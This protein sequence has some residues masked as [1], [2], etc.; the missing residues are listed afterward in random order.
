MMASTVAD[1]VSTSRAPLAA[2]PGRNP[3]R[4]RAR[5]P[6]IASAYSYGVPAL[7]GLLNAKPAA[8][9]D[10]LAGTLARDRTRL[11]SKQRRTAGSTLFPYP[12]LFR[13][14]DCEHKA[15]LASTAQR[16]RAQWQI[17]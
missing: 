1:N 4:L 8:V 14:S 11:F 16:W 10:F 13:S 5:T 9:R 17:M 6:M 2:N 12:T 15:P 7:T 3:L